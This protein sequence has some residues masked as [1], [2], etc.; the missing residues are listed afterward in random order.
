M[1]RAD[2]AAVRGKRRLIHPATAGLVAVSP[3]V[4]F[5]AFNDIAVTSGGAVLVLALVFVL[6]AGVWTAI[7]RL[8]A[9]LQAVAMA[10]LL[11]AVADIQF[12]QSE[13]MSELIDAYGFAGFVVVAAMLFGALAVLGLVLKGNMNGILAAV[14]GVFVGS[15]LAFGVQSPEAGV[16]IDRPAEAMDPTTDGPT[17]EGQTPP[18]VHLILDAHIGLSGMPRDMALTESLR[19][20]MRRLYAK[21]GFRLA[22]DAYSNYAET[23]ISI[24]NLLNFWR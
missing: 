21:H 11:T 17:T 6:T 9:V 15:T 10:G 4:S 14:F 13:T 16:R 7:A 3:V 22:E 20:D 12:S 2:Q 24:S 18:V 8:P 1:T 19:E 23:N 5:L